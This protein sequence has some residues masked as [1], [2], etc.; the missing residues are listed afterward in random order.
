MENI[1][2]IS[3]EWNDWE[4]TQPNSFVHQVM[5]GR[6]GKNFG[7]DSGL[8]KV[9][10]HLYGIQRARYYLIGAESG[11]GK[12]TLA[13]YMFVLSAWR[14]ARK[15]GRRIKIFYFSFEIGSTDKLARWVSYV[16]WT[17]FGQRLPSDYILGRIAG[18][19]VT[20]EH[21]QNI[22]QAY[23][24]VE[25]MMKDVILVERSMTPTQIYNVMVDFYSKNGTVTREEVSKADKL[26][27]IQG[28]A[29]TWVPGPVIVDADVIMIGD[30]I[31]LTED[32]PGKSQKITIDLMSRYC[33][34]LRNLF[35]TTI[36]WI[37]Q[38]S[39]DLMQ[40]SRQ[41][42]QRKVVTYTVPTRLD[43][44]DSK[45]TFRDAD[46]V[47]GLVQIGRE[48]S[49]FHGWSLDRQG[50]LG[51]NA[52]LNVIMK[53]RYGTPSRTVPLFLDGVTGMAE[54]LPVEDVTPET[55]AAY[56]LKARQIDQVCQTFS[57]QQK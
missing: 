11:V 27:G 17:R 50:G 28:E 30:H 29:V 38:F 14:S 36:V 12:T 42:A 20:D 47:F 49:A 33:V 52:I 51:L 48:L 46:V 53:N 45:A 56:Y 16:L 37:Q 19:P 15:A 35:K 10:E 34:K 55:R 54:D 44:G 22:R 6:K 31:A 25:E 1:I 5:I 43:F 4:K 18:V 23:A 9:N 40:Q 24:E 2:P 8:I 32:E 13:D 3:S 41:L 7:L 39:T 21:L 26:K 57:P